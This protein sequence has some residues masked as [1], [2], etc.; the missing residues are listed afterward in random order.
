MSLVRSALLSLITGVA[1]A[2][3]PTDSLP[4]P[5]ACTT[6][7]AER[8]SVLGCYLDATEVLGV[9]PDGPVFWHLYNYPTRAAAEGVKAPHGT[10]V[11]AFGKVWLYV[12]AG[13]DWHPASGTRVA[14]IGPLPV[15]TGASYTARYMEA[16]FNPGMRARAHLHSGP[17]AFY[18]VSGTQCLETPAG[19][20]ISHPGESAVV[21]EGPFMTVQSVGAEPRRS[22]VLVLHDSAK[23]WMTLTSEW[24]PKGLCPH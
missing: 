15:A 18:L 10:V 2:G 22:V 20:T 3:A 9:L 19:I 5:G 12:V 13:A 11:Q 1:L 8:T 7:V 23:P 24:A 16:E 14:V 17:E 21:P 6:P 4:V